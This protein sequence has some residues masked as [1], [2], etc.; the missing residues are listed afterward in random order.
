MKSAFSFILFLACAA[1]AFAQSLGDFKPKDQS[2]GLRKIKNK[3]LYIASFTVNYQVFNEKEDFKQG[4]RMFGGG[5]SKGDA[6]ASLSVGLEGLTEAGVQAVTDKLYQDFTAML[7][8]QGIEIITADEA[9]KTGAYEGFVRMTGGTINE[10]QF[11][12]TLA[13]TP[14]GMNYYVK[15]LDKDGKE[16]SG[17]FLGNAN[18]VHAKLSKDLDDAIVADVDLFILFVEDKDA[19]DIAGA[20]IKV[21]TNLRLAAQEAIQ[22]T[23]NAKIKFKG[24][25]TVTAVNS[26]VGFYSGKMGA[27]IVSSYVGTMGR[28]MGVEGVI[29]D[30]KL[31]SFAKNHADMTGVSTIYGKYYN[32]SNTASKSTTII[33]VDEKKY[34]EGAYLAGK[35][36]IEF[37]TEAFLKEIK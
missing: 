7:K 29:E 4:G 33:P 16:K 5:G 15:K 37:H 19:W 26:Q 21:K 3:R 17:G 20:N 10:A 22:M 12:G 9:G 35:K 31:Q 27:G 8:N 2:Y 34:T 28:S 25:N 1:T 24:S 32:P 6:L 11:P 30:K 23:N 36:F 18:F 13:S 14:T